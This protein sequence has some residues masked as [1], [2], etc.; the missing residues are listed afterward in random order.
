[1]AESILDVDLLAFERG[2][3]RARDAVVDGVRRSLATGFVYTN[4]DLPVDLLD[5]AYGLLQRFFSLD[6]DAK[7]CFRASGSSGQ[8]GY[9]EL[10]V[11]TAAGS[12]HPDWKEMLNWSAPLPMGH[13]LRR[14]F[15]EFYPEQVLPEAAV[16]G[17][18]A[19]LAEFHRAIADL[20]RRFLRVIALGMG[21]GEDFFEEMVSEAPT[22]TR[23]LRYPPM[24]QAPAEGHLWAAAHGDINLI[25]ALPRATGP[26]LQVRVAGEWLDAA[27]PDGRV[28]INTGLMLERLSNGRIPTG[29]HRVV[30]PAGASAER[31]SVV[32]FCHP[33]PWT[34]LAP[35][36]SCCG[37]DQPQRYSAVRAA[38]ALEEVLYRI[39]LL[40]N[41]PLIGRTKG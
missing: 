34:I 14:R 32:Q 23:A 10:L 30:A 28:I 24:V 39:N 12:A 40:E 31:H 36:P 16:P 26:G 33:R 11:E 29:W 15:P 9:T 18:T 41:D 20:Q 17:I 3:Q 38:D 5:S 37:P 22:L 1:M 8:T 2:S 7:R 27:P 35:V 25:T 19:Q 21:C 4:S 6:A 13:P